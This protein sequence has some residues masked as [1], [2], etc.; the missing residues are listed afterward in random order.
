MGC[1]H[2]V[3]NLVKHISEV[4]EGIIIPP[5]KLKEIKS[6]DYHHR[7]MYPTGCGL[8]VLQQILNKFGI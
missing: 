3:I 4:R 8:W 5:L 1:D 7:S 6:V 2:I